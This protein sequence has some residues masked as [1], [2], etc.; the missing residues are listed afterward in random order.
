MSHETE[1]GSRYGAVMMNAFGAPRRIFA[2]G[3]GIH[4]WDADGNRYVDLLAGIAVNAL[5]H[6]HPAVVAAVTGLVLAVRHGSHTTA[7]RR[8]PPRGARG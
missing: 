4:L 2:R 7:P 5:G 1:L 3:E 8:L 6:G